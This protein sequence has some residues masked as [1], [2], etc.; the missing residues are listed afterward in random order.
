MTMCKS[1]KVK[2]EVTDKHVS[3]DAYRKGVPVSLHY[4]Q[5]LLY[6]IEKRGNEV[7]RHIQHSSLFHSTIQARYI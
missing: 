1:K 7:F 4:G 3:V 2:G 5:A 6:M